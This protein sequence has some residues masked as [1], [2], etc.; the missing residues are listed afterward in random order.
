MQLLKKRT[1]KRILVA[2][3]A[4]RVK[5]GDALWPQILRVE[6]ICGSAGEGWIVFAG[7]GPSGMK[8][9][10]EGG[11]RGGSLVVA[12]H[13]FSESAVQGKILSA[14]HNLDLYFPEFYSREYVF[15]EVAD[16]VLWGVSGY[17][18]TGEGA[19][20]LSKMQM[21]MHR[22]VP[23]F[24]LSAEVHKHVIAQTEMFQRDK[25]CSPTDDF[26]RVLDTPEDD[27][28]IFQR[29]EAY[30]AARPHLADWHTTMTSLGDPFRVVPPDAG[31]VAS[32][33]A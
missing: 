11:K 7:G 10:R 9:A 1:G 14:D 20:L 5:E 13:F 25:L 17:G 8:A 24:L 16:A 30:Y 2:Y 15:A 22:Q 26:F 32:K 19:G 6:N 18:G 33:I 27:A 4:G 3:A 12:S 31:G 29:I 23:V 28:A 21:K